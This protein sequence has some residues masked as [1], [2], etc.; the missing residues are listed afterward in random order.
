METTQNIQENIQKAITN[1]NDIILILLY[2]IPIFS[3]CKTYF[4]AENI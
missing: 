3:E 1:G 4:Y 2:F